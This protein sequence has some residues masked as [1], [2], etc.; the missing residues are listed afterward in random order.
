LL[1]LGKRLSI[2]T[3]LARPLGDEEIECLSRFYSIDVSLDTVDPDLLPK[4][5][6]KVALKTIIENMDRIKRAAARRKPSLFSMAGIRQIFRKSKSRPHFRLSCGVY[7]QNIA[8]ILDLCQFAKQ[9]RFRAITFWQLVKYDDVPNG[10]NV[11]PIES[12]EPEAIDNAIAI[13]ER[14]T[15]FL[16][17]NRIASNIAGDFVESWKALRRAS[18]APTAHSL[19]PTPSS[20]RA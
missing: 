20:A 2:I 18:G 3:N 7:D 16:S 14:A 17:A 8:G 11:Y 9:H 19:H 1:D 13:M 12:L 4:I 6:R 5:R 10:Q 15:A